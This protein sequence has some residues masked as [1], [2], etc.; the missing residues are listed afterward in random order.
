MASADH[1][2]LNRE[3]DTFADATIYARVLEVH[4]FEAIVYPAKVEEIFFA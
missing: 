1:A 2:R 3:Q 4:Y